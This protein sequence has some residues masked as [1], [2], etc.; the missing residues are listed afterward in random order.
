MNLV[1]GDST[2]AETW[3]QALEGERAA[4]MVTDPPYCLLTRRRKKGDERDPKGKKNEGPEV[5]R[6]EDVREYRA[7]TQAWMKHAA[8][9]CEPSGP[10]VVWTNLLGQAPIRECAAELGWVHHWGDFTWGKRT[11]ESNSGEELL[12]VVEVAMVFGQQP[13]AEQ[14]LSDGPRCW[15]SVAGYDDDGEAAKWGSHPNHKPFGVLEPLVRQWTK[16][17]TLVVDPF[18]GS[19]SIPAALVRLGRRAAGIELREEWAGRV[20]ERLSGDR[21]LRSAR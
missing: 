3:K 20:R 5:R 6:F 17:G 8:A 19:G 9:S 14:A 11:R 4:A 10:W 16:L 15:A 13:L 21:S 12:R 7:F 2:K 1:H 18:A